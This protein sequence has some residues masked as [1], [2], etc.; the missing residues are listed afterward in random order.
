M[1]LKDFFLIERQIPMTS[2]GYW[3]TPVCDIIPVGFEAHDRYIQKNE[4]MNVTQAVLAG[5]V[6]VVSPRMGGRM[7]IETLPRPTDRCKA[8]LASMAKDYDNYTID[9]MT[10]EGVTSEYFTIWSK[11]ARFMS[12]PMV[13]RP[14]A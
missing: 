11:A 4:N 13:M 9:L 14:R 3:I 1:L 12:D 7:F 10:S 5:W 6:R 8:L 2:Y